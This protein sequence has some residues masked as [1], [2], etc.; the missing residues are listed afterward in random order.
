MNKF[1]KAG[2]SVLLLACLSLLSACTITKPEEKSRTIMVN[3]SAS[4]EIPSDLE[5]VQFTVVTSG[6]SAR[7]IV[8]DNDTI[9]Q[10]F[11][12]AVKDKALSS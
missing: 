5:V 1:G 7:Q 6:W 4:V 3:G 10:R 8:Q 12:N 11:V 9:T 2:I